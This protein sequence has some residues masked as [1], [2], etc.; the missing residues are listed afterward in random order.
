MFNLLQPAIDESVVF[1]APH[2]DE[3]F[4]ERVSAVNRWTWNTRTKHRYT[5]HACD[6]GIAFVMQMLRDADPET[7]YELFS[8]RQHWETNKHDA[9]NKWQTPKLWSEAEF[10][11][12]EKLYQKLV[13][14]LC[15][16]T[17]KRLDDNKIDTLW[18]D[19]P[20]NVERFN[21]TLFSQ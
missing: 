8:K 20:A 10:D 4:P 17:P 2:M 9:R 18:V 5:A 12:L 14:D 13:I 6:E 16:C 7:I 19:G 1:L 11:A 21:I 3:E 15:R